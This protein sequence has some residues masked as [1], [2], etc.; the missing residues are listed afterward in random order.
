MIICRNP[1]LNNQTIFFFGY[2]GD[3]TNRPFLRRINF[4]DFSSLLILS[5]GALKF[6]IIFEI[7]L[8]STGIASISSIKFIPIFSQ[9]NSKKRTHSRFI[10]DYLCKNSLQYSRAKLFLLK[11]GIGASKYLQVSFLKERVTISKELIRILKSYP[12]LRRWSPIAIK[13][14]QWVMYISTQQLLRA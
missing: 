4:P 2:S 6:P 14:S 7:A 12:C 9:K 11:A 10:V 1:E 8:K 13:S 5:F 3:S